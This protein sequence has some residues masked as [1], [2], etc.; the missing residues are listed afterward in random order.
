[1]NTNRN[2]FSAILTSCLMWYGLLAMTACTEQAEY[3]IAQSDI[4][5]YFSVSMNV[6]TE[7]PVS[8][9]TATS[10]EPQDQI[11]LFATLPPA[12]LNSQRYIDNLLLTTTDGKNFSPEQIVYYPTGDASLNF[13]AYHPYQAD[14]LPAESSILPVSIQTDQSSSEN[15]SKSDFLWA[16]QNG[17][18]SSS[19][20]VQLNFAHKFS[21]LKIALVPEEEADL[22]ALADDQ[23]RIVVAGIKTEANCNL[24]NG[25]LSDLQTPSDIIPHGTWTVEENKLVGKELI[26]VPQALNSQ[27]HSIIIEWKGR[28]YV[29]L[30]PEVEL[31]GA[32]QCEITIE[33]RQE[34]NEQLSGIAGSITDWTDAE[35]GGNSNEQNNSIIYTSSLSFA[36]S[37]VYQIYYQ[38]RA[39]AEICKEYLISDQLTSRAIVHYP[40]VSQTGK[41][42]LKNGTVLCLLDKE[43]A[44]CGGKLCWETDGNGFTY[45]EGDQQVVSKFYVGEDG[46]FLANES[47]NAAN[48][49]I[50]SYL[51]RD[52]RGKEVIEYPV[53][54]VGKQYWMQEDLHTTYYQDGTALTP[55]TELGKGAGYFHPADT[56]I[57]FYN[58]EAVLAGELT[59]KEWK[60]PTL[61]DWEILNDYIGGDVSLIKGGNWVPVDNE[62]EAAPA[63]NLTGLSILST[64]GWSK[65]THVMEGQMNS[66]WYMD[67]TGTSITEKIIAFTGESN[68]YIY[69]NSMTGQ[70]G[71]MDYYKALSIR[72]IKE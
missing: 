46:S 45:Q 43:E 27:E 57:Y 52:I 6:L 60:I 4:P 71:A 29:Y 72:C 54:K 63:T 41:P 1:M 14:G 49:D 18:S 65:G 15:F 8:R 11:G 33:F 58:G 44:I 56:D 5:I 31:Q 23:P 69:T 55:Q 48:V 28:I 20:A 47:L 53:V 10:F 68:E 19:E 22:S 3:T 50:I 25:T 59:P 51:L 39:I 66:Y 34:E 12:T 61:A 17:V 2:Y 36:S 30:M 64:G 70:E 35:T 9:T 7:H 37:G 67:E 32:E 13:T 62:A 24:E 40:I 38:G 42:D 16:Q 26:F 21:K